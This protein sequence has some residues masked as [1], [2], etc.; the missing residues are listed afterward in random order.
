[1][2]PPNGNNANQLEHTVLDLKNLCKLHNNPPIFVQIVRAENQINEKTK[3]K[4]SFK[5]FWKVLKISKRSFK[6]TFNQYKNIAYS[7]LNYFFL[8]R[9]FTTV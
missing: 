5:Q 8:F 1:M 7:N 4:N 2:K 6:S 9:I 3:F